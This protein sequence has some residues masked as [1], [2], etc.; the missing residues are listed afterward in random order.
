MRTYLDALAVVSRARDVI[1]S[2]YSVRILMVFEF[3]VQLAGL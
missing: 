2:G 3:A 1:L